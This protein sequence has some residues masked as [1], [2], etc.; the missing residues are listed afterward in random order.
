MILNR[1][2][3]KTC[4]KTSRHQGMSAM[5][6]RARATVF[7]PGITKDIHHAHDSCNYCNRNAPSRAATPPLPFNPPSTPFEKNFADFFD[8]GGSP[9]FSGRG[10]IVR[11]VRCVCY[12]Y[13][14][15]PYRRQSTCVFPSVHILLH[16]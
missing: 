9:L 16:F 10:Q 3:T 13:G 11:L 5:E 7:W 6:R 4:Y 14:V 1:R 15:V 2:T 8:Y 12:T